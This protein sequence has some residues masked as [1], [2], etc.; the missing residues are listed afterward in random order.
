MDSITS[1]WRE[2]NEGCT[3]DIVNKISNCRHEIVQWRNNNPPYGNEKINELQKALEEVQTDNNRSLEDI[4]EV[5]RKLPYKDEEEYWH[6]KSQNM[7]YSSGDL[8]TQFYHALTRQWRI[9]NRIVGLHDAAGS[10]ITKDEG[11]E[12][13]AME[14]FETLFRTSSPSEFDSFFDEV[15]SSI[16]TQ[17]NQRLLR[18]ETEEEVWQTLFMMHPEKSHGPDGMT[19]QFF[20]IPGILSRW[21]W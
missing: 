2:Y 20:S 7:W 19:A 9:R 17:M 4:L 10:W 1:G 14:Y 12:R 8:N 18:P 11:I 3:A 6:Q 13:V 15:M 16:T 21:I 5:S